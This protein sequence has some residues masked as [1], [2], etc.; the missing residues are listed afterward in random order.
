MIKLEQRS[1]QKSDPL[2]AFRSFMA[3]GRQFNRG[4]AFDWQSLGIAAEK[5]ELLF[6]A[7][8]V[9]HYAPGNSAVDLTDK[10]LGVRLA[11]TAETIADPIPAPKRRSVKV[12]A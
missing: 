10:G 2:F 11:E 7:G 9:R 12:A 1:F 5:V 3:H 6:R 4:A 8:K